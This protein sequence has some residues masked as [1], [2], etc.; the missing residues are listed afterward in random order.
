MTNNEGTNHWQNNGNTQADELPQLQSQFPVESETAFPLQALPE[1][2][3]T[4][5]LSLKEKQSFPPDF[6]ACS[7][8]FAASVAAGN[9]Y[10]IQTPFPQ[11]P[12]VYLALVAEPGKLKSHPLAFAKAPLEKWDADEFK[13][14]QSKKKEAYESEQSETEKPTFKQ[15][16]VKDTTPEALVGV[17]QAN[18]GGI[19]LVRDE[20]SAWFKSFNRYHANAEAQFWLSN[21]SLEAISINRKTT[22]PLFV[23]R[24]FISVAGTIQT[25]LLDELASHDR[26]QIGF[27]DRILFSYPAEIPPA[28]WSLNS[29][30]EREENKWEGILQRIAKASSGRF[31]NGQTAVPFQEKALQK[32]VDW[33]H[34]NA[35]KIA[36]A[37]REGN[38]SRAQMLSKLEVY[39]L[40]LSLLLAILDKPEAPQITPGNVSRAITLIDYF[41]ACGKQVREAAGAASLPDRLGVIRY[42]HNEGLKPSD[43]ANTLNV[44]RQYISKV[45]KGEQGKGG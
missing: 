28:K 7:M 33:Q 9:G 37:N 39:A 19:G 14:Y 8:L 11:T 25:A 29:D 40:R 20:L 32:V 27:L 18:P 4:L 38:Y 23:E 45:L 15:N 35:E 17:H 16:L 5:V 34:A 2:L 3:Q 26:A 30:I 31:E 10:Q 22:E 12:L 36:S 42:L 41:E 1:A 24:P 43:I 44:S 6:S 13:T 21:W